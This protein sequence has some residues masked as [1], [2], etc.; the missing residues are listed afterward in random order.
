MD[1]K[2]EQQQKKRLK[3]KACF[4]WSSKREGEEDGKQ[5]ATVKYN[6]RK[7]IGR[8]MKILYIGQSSTIE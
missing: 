1:S 6:Q 3:E 7:R 4:R 5:A 8:L 2:R